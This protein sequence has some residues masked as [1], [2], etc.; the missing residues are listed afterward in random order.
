MKRFVILVS[1]TLLLVGC[2]AE[3][4][5]YKIYWTALDIL[6]EAAHRAISDVV[7]TPIHF[8]VINDYDMIVRA[9]WD[10]PRGRTPQERVELGDMQ[11]KNAIC[12][13]QALP[14]FDVMDAAFSQ[15]A[16]F[17]DRLGNTQDS[18]VLRI[19]VP[20]YVIKHINCD[21]LEHVVLSEV[22]ASYFVD[23]EFLSSR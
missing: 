5:Y 11:A 1:I 14:G 8:V 15:R 6:D 13:L 20:S 12:A 7:D 23:R 22:A 9:Y 16:E 17:T 2:I 18:A 3:E 19:L 4:I 21:N 10:L